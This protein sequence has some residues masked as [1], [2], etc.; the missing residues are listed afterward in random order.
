MSGGGIKLE[1]TKSHL[2]NSEIHFASFLSGF[3]PL[4]AFTYFG[5]VKQVEGRSGVYQNIAVQA[6]NLV[7]LLPKYRF[8]PDYRSEGYIFQFP[9]VRC[10]K[11]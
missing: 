10:L 1:R 6:A 8:P 11:A 4:M 9:P 3:L 5:C 2:N 7:Y